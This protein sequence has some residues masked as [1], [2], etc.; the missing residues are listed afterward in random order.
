M[1]EYSQPVDD[2]Y[3]WFEDRFYD[4]HYPTLVAWEELTEDYRR[5]SEPVDPGGLPLA[6]RDMGFPTPET[7]RRRL[8]DAR[9]AAARPIP[10][11]AKKAGGRG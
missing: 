8:Q 10:P 9:R 5:L 7:H 2:F 4:Y 1:Q 11:K 6:P 3:G